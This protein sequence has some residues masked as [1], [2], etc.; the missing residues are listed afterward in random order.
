MRLPRRN[1]LQFRL[2]ALFVLV[3]LFTLAA[4]TAVLVRNDFSMLRESMVRDL[5]ILAQVIGENSRS[6]DLDV[7]RLARG[8][9]VRRGG[10]RLAGAAPGRRERDERKENARY[11]YIY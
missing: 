9:V 4:A 10:T 1:S 8:A 2:V 11:T 5:E 6:D 7:L 3:S